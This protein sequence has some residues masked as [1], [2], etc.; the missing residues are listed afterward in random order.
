MVAVSSSAVHTSTDSGDTWVRREVDSSSGFTGQC[1]ASS[2]DGTKLVVG[3]TGGPIFTSITATT[4]G[5]TGF[6]SGGQFSAVEL[7]HIGNGQFMPISSAG[8][9]KP[10]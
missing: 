5:S 1:V 7:Q 9:I 6:L 8:T 2:A 4:S 3:S 10:Y